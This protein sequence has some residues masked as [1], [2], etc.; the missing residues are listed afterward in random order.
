ML[1]KTECVATTQSIDFAKIGI[2]D[3]FCNGG[4]IHRAGTAQI[5]GAENG[6]WGFR[7]Q[8]V[9]GIVRKVPRKQ[10]V[11]NVRKNEM[12]MDVQRNR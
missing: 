12:V 5:S 4:H 1:D 11:K 6:E 7:G 9:P 3:N 10:K 2:S 8:V